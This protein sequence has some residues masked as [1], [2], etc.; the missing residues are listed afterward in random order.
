VL[1]WHDEFRQFGAQHLRERLAT[2]QPQRRS[3]D[4]K[5]K[6][7]NADAEKAGRLLLDETAQ[8]QSLSRRLHHLRG[9]LMTDNRHHSSI[10]WSLLTQL[11][12]QLNTWD[13][14][15]KCRHQGEGSTRISDISCPVIGHFEPFPRFQDERPY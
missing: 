12:C 5:K 6:P 9:D 7:V 4:G 10:I 15:R 8:V 3:I 1:P 14:A 13:N 11:L 2:E